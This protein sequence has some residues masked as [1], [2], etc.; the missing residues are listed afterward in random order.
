MQA[1]VAKLLKLLGNDAMP[2]GEE[3]IDIAE[4]EEILWPLQDMIKSL[5]Q[6]DT[7]LAMAKKAA[8]QLYDSVPADARQS[9]QTF[10][11]WSLGAPP[12]AVISKPSFL[13]LICC[14][15]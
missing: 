11:S 1:G 5:Q 9:R 3:R 12:K 7:G 4:A 6:G 14:C 8:Q 10:E 2:L 13:S 15:R